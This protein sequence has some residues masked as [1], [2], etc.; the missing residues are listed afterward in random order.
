MY[1]LEKWNLKGEKDE[2]GNCKVRTET[3][4]LH[5][6]VFKLA[7]EIRRCE[8]GARGLRFRISLFFSQP[9]RLQ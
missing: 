9:S 1:A 7:C 8:E 6:S 5:L 2:T 4:G 3:N